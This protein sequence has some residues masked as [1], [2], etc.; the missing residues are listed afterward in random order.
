MIDEFANV[1]KPNGSLTRGKVVPIKPE[2]DW[3]T[4]REAAQILSLSPDMVKVLCNEQKLV[5]WRT[6]GGGKGPGHRR[7]SRESVMEYK[8]KLHRENV[9][10]KVHSA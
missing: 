5:H 9:H 2:K 3:L 6:E 8:A 4:T 10:G 7:I 1:L